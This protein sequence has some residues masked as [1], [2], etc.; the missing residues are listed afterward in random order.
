MSAWPITGIDLEVFLGVLQAAGDNADSLDFDGAVAAAAGE[1]ESRT[2]FFPFVSSGVPETRVFDG[3]WD[4][5]IR[6]SGG[7]VSLSENGVTINGA[8][9]AP[10]F[11]AL[12]PNNAPVMGR[13]YRS[14]KFGRLQE[15]WLPVVNGPAEDGITYLGGAQRVIGITGMW[16][17]CTAATLPPSVK[18]AVL[19]RAAALIS[20]QIALAITKGLYSARD[21]NF[22]LRFAGGKNSTLGGESEAWNKIFESAV[23]RPE[24]R[25]SLYF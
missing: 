8:I 15:G 21:M 6:F 7:L 17:F 20:P 18:N 16:G 14:V 9:Y 5:A 19:C 25:A 24:F 4:N 1:W 22:E 11:Y 12:K 23:T 10:T 3:Q 13:P 2:G